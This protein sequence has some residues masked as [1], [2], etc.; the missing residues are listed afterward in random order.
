MDH[1]ALLN[2]VY[3]AVADPARWPDVLTSISDQVDGV[4]GMLAYNAPP[5][6]KNLIV[7]GRLDPNYNDIFHKYHVWNP[8]TLAIREQ[9]FDRAIVCGSLVERRVVHKTAFYADVLAPQKIHDMLCIS[10]RGLA[11]N[12]GVGGIGFCLSARGADR[13]EHNRRRLQ[14]VVP[15]LCRALDVTLQLGPLVDGSRQLTRVLQLMPNA[16]LLLDAK[17]RILHA[18]P[19]A[20]LLL[21]DSD[22]LTCV[23]GDGLQLSATLPDE[24]VAISHAL[25]KALRVAAGSSDVLGEPVRLTRPSGTAPLLVIPV[26]L[27]P[28]A[29]PLWDLSQSARI[30]VLVVDP[31]T[32][33]L[34]AASALQTVFGLTHAEVRVATLVGSGLSGPQAAQVLGVSPAT[35]KTHL[36]RCFD[37][38]G[39]RS[40]IE[41]A[42]MLSAFPLDHAI[43]EP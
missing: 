27:P 16:A 9:P 35:V 11:V 33:N 7:L 13:A 15:H 34:A 39:I 36:A 2:Q 38:M 17:G 28:S 26:P 42:R 29:F 25:E 8:W 40:Q 22:G 14:R 43:F 5:G 20:E 19:A 18:N 31:R 23:S 37:K 41:L 10:H 24:S 12:G 32:R 21:R 3:G 6:G 30:L 4:G 1:E